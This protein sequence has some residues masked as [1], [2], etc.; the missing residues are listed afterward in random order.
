MVNVC[1]LCKSHAICDELF[2]YLFIAGVVG[3]QKLIQQYT[4]S[5]GDIVNSPPL[6]NLLV[7]PS[8]RSKVGRSSSSVSSQSKLILMM[9]KILLVPYLLK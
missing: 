7:S 2:V 5:P 6:D 3:V 8:R 9:I 1:I 4:V